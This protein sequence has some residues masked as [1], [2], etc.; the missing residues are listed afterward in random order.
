M[1]NWCTHPA[2]AVQQHKKLYNLYFLA[3]KELYILYNY[4]TAALVLLHT[5]CT[6]HSEL[7]CNFNTHK[8]DY[9]YVQ[10]VNIDK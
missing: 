8:E 6:P 7:L 10:E 4:C 1:Y 9:K 2:V 3:S 5:H